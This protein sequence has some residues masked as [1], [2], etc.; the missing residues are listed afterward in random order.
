MFTKRQH[1]FRKQKSKVKARIEL[2]S[3]L[4]QAINEGNYAVIESLNLSTAFDVII[5]NELLRR[6][7][8]MGIPRDVM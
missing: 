2:Q 8:N 6:L 3:L 7:E 5:V 1:G 4:V